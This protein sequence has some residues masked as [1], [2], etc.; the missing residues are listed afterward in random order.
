[1]LNIEIPNQ[2]IFVDPILIH[3]DKP[4]FKVNIGDYFLDL[5]TKKIQQITHEGYRCNIIFFTQK[6]PNLCK[7][8]KSLKYNG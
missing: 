2:N 7:L 5:E 1:M 6:Y 8:I 3:K 4:Y